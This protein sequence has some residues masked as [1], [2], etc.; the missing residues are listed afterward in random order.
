MKKTEEREGKTKD[1]KRS[2][3]KDRV[4]QGRTRSE[5]RKKDEMKRGI[6]G[7]QRIESRGKEKRREREWRLMESTG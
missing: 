2:K 4:E 1:N 5:E 7:R 3:S 6:A